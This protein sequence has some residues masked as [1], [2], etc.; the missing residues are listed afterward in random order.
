MP[1]LDTL[2]PHFAFLTSPAG[3]AALVTLVAIQTANGH[4]SS[5]MWEHVAVVRELI[6]HPFDPTHPQLASPAAHPGFSP[7]TVVLGLIGN[8]TGA[9]AI[10]LLSVA[11]VV[12][13]VALLAALRWFVLE[14]T[15]NARASGNGSTP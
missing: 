6:A 14:V 1:I 11:A 4:W 13:V 2:A 12:N 5:D 8:A 7:Y 10:P 15:R 9:S 3:W